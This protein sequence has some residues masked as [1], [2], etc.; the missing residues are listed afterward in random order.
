MNSKRSKEEKYPEWE[1]IQPL[2]SSL[3][4]TQDSQTFW[5]CDSCGMGQTVSVI[6]AAEDR[7]RLLDITG[8]RNRPLK[9]V[10]RARVILLSAEHLPAG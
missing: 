2:T 7:E 5:I 3:T 6:V 4:L 8:D 10:Q 9:H 1:T